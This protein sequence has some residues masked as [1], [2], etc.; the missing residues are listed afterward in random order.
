MTTRTAEEANLSDPQEERARV[1]RPR[2]GTPSY[3][4]VAKPQPQ[5]NPEP[6]AT[7]DGLDYTHPPPPHP[8]DIH[9][10]NPTTTF[11][12]LDNTQRALWN[13]E[14]GEKVLAYKAYGGRIEDKDEV[15]KLGEIIKAGLNLSEDPSVATPVPATKSKK[16]L[17][18]LCAL[19]GGLP[20][21]KVRVLLNM[22]CTPPAPH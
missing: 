13:A 6:V 5:Q 17:P 7:L 8:L 20:P 12:N 1:V 15:I 18:P 4:S 9:G 10:W 19:I 14:P 21:A 16:H 2:I 22:V 11:K 3:A